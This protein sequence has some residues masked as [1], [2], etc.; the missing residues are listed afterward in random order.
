M[1][2]YSNLPPLNAAIGG[3]AGI[4][5]QD[6]VT[7]PKLWYQG[8][9]VQAL[10]S[11]RSVYFDQSNANQKIAHSID[12]LNECR[13]GSL[14]QADPDNLD[15]L[16]L[17]VSP[18][19]FFDDYASWNSDVDSFDDTLFSALGSDI[20]NHIFSLGD[21]DTKE[22]TPAN[23]L[24]LNH[25]LTDLPAELANP[26]DTRPFAVVNPLILQQATSENPTKSAEIVDAKS[27]Q[28]ER[29]KQLQRER[30]RN[31]HAYAE[32]HREHQRELRRNPDYVER[33][34]KYQ[35]ERYR[36]D[37]AYA[38]RQRERGRE[39]RRNP[40]HAERQRKHQRERYRND[41][42]YAERQRRP[43]KNPADA[44]RRRERT[45][46]RKR[47]RYRNDPDYAK[48]ERERKR[49]YRNNLTLAGRVSR[50]QKEFYQN[51]PVYAEGQRVYANT[52]NKM[53][54]K[55]SKEEASKL[56]KVAREEYLQSANLPEGSGDSPRTSNP[57]ETTQNSNKNLN[58]LPLFPSQTD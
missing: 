40:A 1:E 26:Q 16:D 15:G 53:R 54:R 30:Y 22:P 7:E 39:L 35:R 36:N 37:P 38:E 32:R 41:P 19:S 3:S 34:R 49:K 28:G 4:S 8:K 56:A 45:R 50:H 29:K 47:E 44:E 6:D 42:D 55:V 52:Y 43:C 18:E 2:R 11:P 10:S 21:P 12:S 20:F 51:N 48:R 23:C 24:N 5:Y 57:A 33:E 14:L 58:L 46:E 31:D 13:V 9:S 27:S 25:H 17:S